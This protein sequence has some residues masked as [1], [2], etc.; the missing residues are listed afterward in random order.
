MLMGSKPDMPEAPDI[1]DI[2]KQVEERVLGEVKEQIDGFKAAAEKL[3][4]EV[5]KAKKQVQ[6]M[7]KK[8]KDMEQMAVQKL[9][10]EVEKVTKAVEEKIRSEFL[11]M[12]N[13]VKEKIL[14]LAKKAT[15]AA[16]EKIKEIVA[17]VM[18]EAQSMMSNLIQG[19]D[20]S[21]IIKPTVKKVVTEKLWPDLKEAIITT[22]TGGAMKPTNKK[23]GWGLCAGDSSKEDEPV[24]NMDDPDGT[25]QSPINALLTGF[26]DSLSDMVTSIP[27]GIPFLKGDEESKEEVAEQNESKEEVT[28]QNESKEEEEVAEQNESKEEEVVAEQNESKE[29]VAEQNESKEEVAKQNESKEDV[30]DPDDIHM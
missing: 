1:D 27:D 25:P 13:Q 15:T 19:S 21:F 2:K 18:D 6:D 29:E 7:E 17:M 20:L 30:A 23:G 9:K 16:I 14:D 28:E 8:I 3:K 22:L 26:T 5:E 4:E 24:N 11:P 12:I 10:E